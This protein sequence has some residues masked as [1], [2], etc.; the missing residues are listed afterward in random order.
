MISQVEKAVR[1]RPAA[2]Q[3]IDGSETCLAQGSAKTADGACLI[4][5]GETWPVRHCEFWGMLLHLMEGK[6]NPGQD[7]RMLDRVAAVYSR[8]RKLTLMRADVWGVGSGVQCRHG[9]EAP[10]E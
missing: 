4:G 6:E 1:V 10:Q 8:P 3:T 2:S 9:L 7:W 5:E